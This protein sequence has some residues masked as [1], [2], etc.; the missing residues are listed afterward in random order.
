MAAVYLPCRT[1]RVCAV[2]VLIEWYGVTTVKISG[3]WDVVNLNVKLIG[4]S[5]VASYFN[6]N[7]IFSL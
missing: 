1:F 6:S 7:F 3:N 5:I 2:Q 4:F